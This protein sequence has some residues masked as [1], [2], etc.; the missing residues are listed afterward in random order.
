M[1]L[2]EL[3]N[4]CGNVHGQKACIVVVGS[5][6]GPDHLLL[7]PWEELVMIVMIPA[8]TNEVDSQVLWMVVV[9][10]GGGRGRGCGRCCRNEAVTG[11]SQVLVLGELRFGTAEIHLELAEL[12][13]EDRDDAHA[14]VNWVSEPHVSLISQGVDG[15]FALVWVQFVEKLRHVA[16]TKHFVHVGKLLGLVRWEVWR[17]HT[18]R[19]TLS[20]EKLTCCTWRIG[21]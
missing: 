16:G 11:D 21:R 5:I 9:I 19:L 3:S 2:T 20:P 7:L 18:L 15:V 6:K 12:V 1:K 13:L 14:A 8:T 10:V 17:K 4:A